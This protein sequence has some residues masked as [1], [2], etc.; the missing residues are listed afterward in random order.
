MTITWPQGPTPLHCITLESATRQFS[1]WAN[2]RSNRPGLDLLELWLD[3]ELSMLSCC[4]LLSP[5]AVDFA[6]PRGKPAR[7]KRAHACVAIKF[8]WGKVGTF[9][10]V[11]HACVT[12]TGL[13]SNEEIK[14]QYIPGWIEL[15]LQDISD[16]VHQTSLLSGI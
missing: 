13:Y 9:P 12:I 7:G 4:R 11:H 1:E 15:N 3:D 8:W 5:L 10:H 14:C 16:V 6:K 2:L